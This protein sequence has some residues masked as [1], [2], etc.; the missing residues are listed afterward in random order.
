MFLLL[1]Y[2]DC[3]HRSGKQYYHI[4]VLL[5]KNL[6]NLTVLKGANFHHFS[7]IE[8]ATLLGEGRKDIIKDPGIKEVAETISD[9]VRMST[10]L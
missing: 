4:V 3:I 2:F 7:S 1:E 5:S 8:D 6:I 9:K 10:K